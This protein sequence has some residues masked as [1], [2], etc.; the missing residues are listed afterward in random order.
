MEFATAAHVAETLEQLGFKVRL[1]TDACDASSRLGVPSKQLLDMAYHD[2]LKAGAHPR[3]LK[4]M[5]GGLTAVVADLPASDSAHTMAFRFDMDALPVAESDD[6]SH[7]PARLE[8]VSQLPGLMH[9]C[10]HDAHTAI[11]LSLAARLAQDPPANSIRLLFQPAEEGCRGAIAMRNAGCVDGVDTLVCFH[12]G[13]GVP[14]GHVYSDSTGHLATTKFRVR[15]VGSAAH[16][17]RAPEE[18][19][20]A[21]LAACTA[22]LNIHA[23]PR[24]S[25]AITRV[26][27]GHVSAPGAPN[28]VPAT[29]TFE[30]ETRAANEA[31][32]KDL[33]RRIHRIVEHSALMQDVQSEVEVIGSSTVIHCDDSLSTLIQTVA[34]TVPGVTT[35]GTGWEAGGSEDASWLIREVQGQGGTG[36]YMVVGAS[37]PG[38]HH[39][40]QFDVD[41]TALPIAVDL[42]DVIARAASRRT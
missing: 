34:R 19:K 29:A 25:H 9:A 15:L 22:I 16:A 35:I 13:L 42:L 12:L 20:N 26:N 3:I 7:G 36:T 8:F 14:T 17:G 38:P 41:E 32:N 37:S 11:G 4:K 18:G 39:S 6:L 40:N 21:L 33:E 10:G 27:V 31:V 2:A 24:Y 1:G 30:L 23:L 5:R 28:I